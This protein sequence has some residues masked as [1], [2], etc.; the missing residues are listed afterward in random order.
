MTFFKLLLLALATY[1]VSRML[2]IEDGPFEIFDWLR[3]VATMLT[4]RTQH[5]FR[6]DTLITCQYCNSVWVALPLVVIVRHAIG[7]W[8]VVVLAVSALVIPLIRFEE[9]LDV[10]QANHP[11]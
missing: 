2:A 7:Y 10:Y 3:G 6:F 11:S 4:L 8:V 1:R 9:W 5:R